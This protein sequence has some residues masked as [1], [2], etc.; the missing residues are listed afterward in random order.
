M[1]EVI[2][3]QGMKIIEDVYDKEFTEKRLDAYRTL[4]S[5]I[6]ESL[7][8][9]GINKMLRERVYPGIPTPADIRN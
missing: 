9:D 7:F 3:L 1:Q 4:L 5:D 2:F 6:P 8:V